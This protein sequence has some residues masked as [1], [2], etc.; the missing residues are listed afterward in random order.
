MKTKIMFYYDE[1]V[2]LATVFAD[3]YNHRLQH[4][5]DLVSYVLDDYPEIE[6]DDI[7]LCVFGPPGYER[8]IG[9]QFNP[10]HEPSEKYVRSDGRSICDGYYL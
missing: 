7:S 2:N 9:V 10:A 5:H 4:V 3:S 8:M 6:P 1:K